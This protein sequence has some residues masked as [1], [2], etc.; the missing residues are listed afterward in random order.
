MYRHSVTFI[1][2]QDDT[3]I[4]RL[5]DH[6]DACAKAGGRLVA[7]TEVCVLQAS[8]K[9]NGYTVVFEYLVEGTYR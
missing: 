6:L 8:G 7:M 4:E 5:Q 9:L 2:Y 1:K 3:V